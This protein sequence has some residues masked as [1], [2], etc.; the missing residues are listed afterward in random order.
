MLAKTQSYVAWYVWC[1]ICYINVYDMNVDECVCKPKSCL[2]KDRWILKN[3]D[4]CQGKWI[5]DCLQGKTKFWLLRMRHPCRLLLEKQGLGL[6]TNFLETLVLRRSLLENIWLSW[7]ALRMSLHPAW[8]IQDLQS[9]R[10]LRA[11]AG[12]L[13][14]LGDLRGMR[15]PEDLYWGSSESDRLMLERY[16]WEFSVWW[17]VSLWEK[18]H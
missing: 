14:F 1:K 3:L 2:A 8:G 15:T 4:C 11:T 18:F 5:L 9:L 17:Q 7:E 12:E 13:A 16:D 6:Y 10:D